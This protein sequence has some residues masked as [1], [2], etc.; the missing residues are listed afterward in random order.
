[1]ENLD[2]RFQSAVQSFWDTRG[3]QQQKQIE[4][5]KL[6]AG[7][8]GSVTGGGQMGALEALTLELLEEVG[9][10]RLDVRI[11]ARLELPGYYRAVKKW[12]L[13][14]VSAGKLVMALEFKSQVGSF[15]NNQN[16]RIEEALGNS[17]DI[18]TAFREG[19]LGPVRPLVGYFLLLEDSPQVHSPK[20]PKSKHFDVDP[21]FSG[22]SY[23]KR[24]EIFCQRM[25]LERNYDCACLTL[26]TQ[27]HPTR[28]SHPEESLDFR[29]FAAQLQAHAI[30]FKRRQAD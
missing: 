20:A 24:Y 19:R 5:G 7:T 27:E 16:N 6:D 3:D 22:A 4:S 15:G 12:D 2:E 25:V 28:V 8:R 30:G 21:V 26:A 23:A 9:L 14:V 11:G 10:D 18:W 13:L 17:V 29:Q 1:M